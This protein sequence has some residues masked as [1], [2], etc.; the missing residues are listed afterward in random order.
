MISFYG[1]KNCGTC[2]KAEKWLQAKGLDYKFIDITQEPPEAKKLQKILSQSQKP[3]NKWFNTSG[4]VYR[5]QKIKDKLPKLNEAESV[6]LLAAN[7]KLIKR[8]LVTDGKT[9]TVGFSEDEFQSC[10]K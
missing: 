6:K 4:Q 5:E 1:Y 7:G 8:P 9:S 2:K 3:M 10:W